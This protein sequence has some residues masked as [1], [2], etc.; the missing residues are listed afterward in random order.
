MFWNSTKIYFFLIL[1]KNI[2]FSY[3]AIKYQCIK[4]FFPVSLNYIFVLSNINAFRPLFPSN[5]MHTDLFSLK[6]PTILFIY[7]GNRK[8]LLLFVAVSSNQGHY[9]SFRTSFHFFRPFSFPLSP[10]LSC[11]RV[12]Q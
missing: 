7:N 4:C 11:R 6:I 1:L 8:N 5:I 9:P 10:L 12:S 2:L 3:F